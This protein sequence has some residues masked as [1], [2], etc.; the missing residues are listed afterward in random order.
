MLDEVS[1]A[2][3]ENLDAIH[4][5]RYDAKEDAGAIDEVAFLKELGLTQRSMV[6]DVGA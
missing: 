1:S 5:S 3:R 4:I 2:G 6:I